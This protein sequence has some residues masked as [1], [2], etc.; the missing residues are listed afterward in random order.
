MKGGPIRSA[1]EFL[2]GSST[3]RHPVWIGV[4]QDAPRQGAIAAL[5]CFRRG[6]G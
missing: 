3:G 1:P 6:R 2:A 5:F 4:P